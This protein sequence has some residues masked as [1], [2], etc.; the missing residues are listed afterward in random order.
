MARRVEEGYRIGCT[1]RPLRC[2]CRLLFSLTGVMKKLSPAQEREEEENVAR[3]IH[4]HSHTHTHIYTHTHTHTHAH[5]HAHTQ[6]TIE[7]IYTG[8]SNIGAGRETHLEET[9]KHLYQVWEPSKFWLGWALLWFLY[10][11]S[12]LGLGQVQSKCSHI[13]IMVDI[14]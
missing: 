9:G 4:T 13:L 3:E 12:K 14:L 2:C 5:A 6:K 1:N 7:C 8:A 11:Q 10:S